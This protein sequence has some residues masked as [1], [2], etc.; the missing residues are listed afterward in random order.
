M[1]LSIHNSRGEI[2]DIT[3]DNLSET[4]KHLNSLQIVILDFSRFFNFINKVI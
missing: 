1:T 3:I 2:T 4:L